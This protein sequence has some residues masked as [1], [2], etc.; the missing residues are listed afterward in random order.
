MTI[1]IGNL[2]ITEPFLWSVSLMIISATSRLVSPN[3]D[4]ADWVFEFIAILGFLIYAALSVTPGGVVVL[5]GYLWYRGKRFDAWR[6][7][8]KREMPVSAP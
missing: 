5:L 6:K 7:Q 1:W 2:P 3:K 8:A 4:M